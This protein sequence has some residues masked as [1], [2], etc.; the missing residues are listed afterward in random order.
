MAEHDVSSAV[1]SLRRDASALARAVIDRYVD[2]TPLYTP[3]TVPDHLYRE[4]L[5]TVRTFIDTALRAVLDADLDVNGLMRDV[6]VRGND[7]VAEGL[8]LRNYLHCWQLGLEALT[9][10]LDDRLADQATA[11]PALARVREVY[12]AVILD[13]VIAYDRTSRDVIAAQDGREARL[14]AHHLDGVDY[15]FDDGPGTVPEHP[16][17]VLVDIGPTL[18]EQTGSEQTRTIAAIRKSRRVRATLQRGVEGLWLADVRGRSARLITSCPPR[19]LDEVIGELQDA[20]SVP[21]TAAVATANGADDL[22]RAAALAAEVLAIAVRIGR[23]GM[24]SSIEDIAL[25]HHLAHESAS[26]P[27]L[28][29]RC[30]PLRARHDLVDTLL[31]Y[32][33]NDLDRRRTAD[34]LHVHPNTIDN[35]LSRIR[36][37][38]DLDVR[39]FPD[40]MVLAVATNRAGGSTDP[41]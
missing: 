7:R 21:V 11:A 8:P 3:E 32:F 23:T 36:D 15:P 26:L 28:L 41:A 14:I 34:A 16:V 35:R 17:V 40:L 6:L 38:T 24:V 22:P 12:D 33:D 31:A 13:A 19:A 9:E 4:S 18:A 37:L 20:H 2:E 1:R 29:R 30:A 39:H 10:A 25:E 5:H 27:V